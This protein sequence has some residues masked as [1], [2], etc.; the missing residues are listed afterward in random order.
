MAEPRNL[1][2]LFLEVVRRRG[3]AVALRYKRDGRWLG[4]TWNEWAAEVKRLAWA[5]VKMGL[6]PR[7]V[8][9]IAA[10]NRHEW[11]TVDLAVQMAGGILVPIYPTLLAA[12]AQ[13]ITNNCQAR[14]AVVEDAK[15]LAKVAVGADTLPHL[16]QI[17]LIDGAADDPR[18][19]SYKAFR[20]LG[21]DLDETDLA[22]RYRDIGPGDIVTMVYTSGTTGLPK[23]AMLTHDNFLFISDAVLHFFE[24]APGDVVLSFLPLSHIYARAGEFYPSLRAGIEICFA[25]S[26]DKLSENL[27]EVRPTILCTVPRVLE[28]VYA[29]IIAK[30]A[31]APAITRKLFTWALAVGRE[32]APYREKNQPLPAWLSLQHRLAKALVYD[33]I[34]ARFGGRVRLL[35]VAGAPMSREIAEYFYALDVLTL[36]AYGMTECSDPATLNTLR[37]HRFGTVGLPLPGVEIKIAPDGEI[38]MRSRAVFAGYFNLPEATAETLVDGW[39]HTG[40]IGEF[41]PD[42]MLRIT[43]RKKDLIVTS[44]GKNI[45]P[46]KI[47]SMLIA[48]P[49]IA[50]AVVLGDKLKYLTALIVPA[51]DALAPV[52][53]EQGFALPERAAIATCQP[54]VDLI[55]GRIAEINQRLAKFET[56]KDFRLLDHDLTLESG[57]L[58]PTLKV[59]RKVVQQKFA[60]LIAEMYPEIPSD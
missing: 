14:I 22:A 27:V 36:E 31:V 49:F 19:L 11:V 7:G 46:Q 41:D 37:R 10:K 44:G 3:D 30:T 26:I 15:Q 35:A 38:L 59:K 34:A 21:D 50:Q 1:V 4:I 47:E 52:V 39:L 28:K 53:R 58:T 57:E 33:K 24:I 13:Y 8:V 6:P 9:T 25:E 16:Q 43:D 5:F 55:R 20:R 51:M 54:A 60:S 12:E 23:G 42:G 29:A 17:I 32:S 18:V 48:D 45:A 40:D 56:V 2:E